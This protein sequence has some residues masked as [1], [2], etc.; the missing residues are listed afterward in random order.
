[1]LSKKYFSSIA[2]RQRATLI[3]LWL[4]IAFVL[5]LVRSV[6]LPFVLAA[7]LAYVLQPLV[8][9]LTNIKIKDQSMPRWS[10]VFLIYLIF[11]GITALVS[12]FF[13]PQFYL[14]VVRL[15][16]DASAFINSI[17]EHS[18]NRFGQKIEEFFN[19]YQLPFE[20]VS[21]EADKVPSTH[22]RANWISID[23]Y[24]ISQT[25][26]NDIILYIKSEARSIISSAQFL[27][28]QLISIL[29]MTL[30]VIMITGFMLVDIER[31]KH[32]L[33]SMVPVT[34]RAS[35][36]EFLNRLDQRL[37]GVVRGQL[38]ICIVNAIFT[39]A[40]LLILDVKFAFTLATMA[41]IFSIVPIFGS[42]VSTIPIVLVAL[43]IS[44]LTALFSLLWIIG[45][46]ILE[47][48]LLNPK[49]M[50]HSAKIHPILILLALV[51]GENF[52]GLIGALLAV[53]IMS[54]VVTAFSS[55]LAKAGLN[56]QGVANPVEDDRIDI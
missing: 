48:N 30:L 45:I 40:G 22:S 53:P 49:I 16:K 3:S 29:F 28:S 36:D 52:Y 35:F 27:F 4:I 51:I 25:V 15:I 32:F 1:L 21:S 50:G 34:D 38:T 19:T 2:F 54:I 7:L 44:P 39:L 12:I 41:G 37:S 56:G 24:K 13:I 47:A 31:I 10:A 9:F 5:I 18:I 23:L 43:T 6:I 17:D 20:I 11:A 55:I 26:L 42:I 8:T 46:H 33:F 14:E